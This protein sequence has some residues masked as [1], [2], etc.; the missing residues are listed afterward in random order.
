[1][2]TIESLAKSEGIGL[3]DVR[4]LYE[5]VL[6]ELRGEAV[7]TDFLPIFA[8]RKV[9]EILRVRGLPPSRTE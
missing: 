9:R 3:E 1:S 5:S 2:S 8:A 7:I 4:S 6:E